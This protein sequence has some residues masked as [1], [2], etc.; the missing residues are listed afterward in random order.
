MKKQNTQNRRQFFKH[1]AKLAL[2]LGAINQG[3]ANENGASQSTNQDIF[4]KSST[5]SVAKTH[6]ARVKTLLISSHPYPERSFFI[7]GLEQAAGRVRGVQVRNLESVYGFDTSRIDGAAERALTRDFERVAFLFPTH[8]FNITPMMKAY[9]NEAW[10]SVGPGLWQGKE[11]LVISTAAGGSSTYGANGRVGVELKD[12]F[13][14]MKASA[15]HCGMRY[16]EP[17]VFQGVSS[18]ELGN[19]QNALISRLTT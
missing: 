8:W 12:I 3:F 11:M 1:S 9:L 7:K 14:S 16:L 2:A 5:Q 13:L 15:L 4:M 10:G 19:Y 6:D 17:L 18:S